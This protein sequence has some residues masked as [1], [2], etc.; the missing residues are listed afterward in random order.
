MNRNSGSSRTRAG[1][2]HRARSA[3]T[4]LFIVAGAAVARAD[5]V[6]LTVEDGHGVYRVHGT[7]TA[8]VSPAVAWAVLTDYD[9][10]GAYVKSIRASA[11][12]RR[13]DG[14]LLLRQS[15]RGGVFPLQRTVHVL[16]DVREDHENRITFVDR[17]GQDFHLYSGDWNVRA[18]G[19]ETSVAYS[20]VARPIDA[21]PHALGRGL[22]GHQARELLEQVRAEMVRRAG[23]AAGSGAA[24]G[25]AT[26]PRLVG[27]AI[28]DPQRVARGE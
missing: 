15:A 16:L 24:G 21:M 9:H 11:V 27:D 20:L 3:L 13:G 23:P 6:S 14:R 18:A 7:F 25:R 8:P 4:A 22:M 1:A 10:I 2:G 12:E 28:G 26:V 5:N 17:L 19:S